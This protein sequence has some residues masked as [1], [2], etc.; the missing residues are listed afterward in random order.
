MPTMSNRVCRLL[1]GKRKFFHNF[2]I[3]LKFKMRL[4]KKTIA[5]DMAWSKLKKRTR[6]SGF[7]TRC[8]RAHALT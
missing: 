7:A 1:G 8:A 3:G 6:E 2:W 5:N 4:L